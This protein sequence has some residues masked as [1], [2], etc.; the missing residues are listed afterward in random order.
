MGTKIVVRPEG[1]RD[2]DEAGHRASGPARR[3]GRLRGCGIREDQ[4]AGARFR[5]N[6]GTDPELRDWRGEQIALVGRLI[7]EADPAPLSSV[8]TGSDTS[9]R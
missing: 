7:H 3:Q 8:G 2:G 4:A 5:A 6:Y 1:G 9:G